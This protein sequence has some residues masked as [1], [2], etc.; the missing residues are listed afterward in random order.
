VAVCDL[1]LACPRLP[2]S[3]LSA[4]LD[5]CLQFYLPIMEPSFTSTICV[6]VIN[7]NVVK[8]D[9]VATCYFDYNELRGIQ[10]GCS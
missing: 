1:T 6:S 9:L 5:G 10:V 7:K 4:L 2:W 3:P 8:D